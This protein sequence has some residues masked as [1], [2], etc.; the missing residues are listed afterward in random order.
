M[1]PQSPVTFRWLE[2]ALL[3]PRSTGSSELEVSVCGIRTKPC[4]LQ[5]QDSFWLAALP[6]S[7]LLLCHPPTCL[8]SGL[9]PQNPEG[10]LFCQKPLASE[11][12]IA[13]RDGKM[14][15]FY[16]A[17]PQSRVSLQ[18]HSIRTH[19]KWPLERKRIGLLEEP[20]SGKC[21]IWRSIVMAVGLSQPCAWARTAAGVDSCPAWTHTPQLV[22]QSLWEPLQTTRGLPA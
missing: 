2:S 11:S 21:S 10:L 18:V 16:G 5:T 1:R 9:P 7:F 22:P 17:F 3:R 13:S 15:T 4:D 20:G 8:A 12:F 14:G 19:C 6:S